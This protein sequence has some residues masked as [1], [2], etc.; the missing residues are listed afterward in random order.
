MKVRLAIAVLCD[1]IRHELNGKF[2]VMGVF[3]QWNVRDFTRPL[4]PCHVFARLSFQDPGEYP[5]TVTFRT[6]QGQQLFSAEGNI[7]VETKD[8][9]SELYFANIDLGLGNLSV[10]R[11]G[12]YEFALT[13]GGELIGLIPC[14]A[15]VVSP[16]L[17]Q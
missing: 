7:Q 17:V 2:S 13:V 15:V 6:V 5:F 16:P 8:Q 12:Q 10:P 4:P 9:G 1:D 14:G 3:T 11:P